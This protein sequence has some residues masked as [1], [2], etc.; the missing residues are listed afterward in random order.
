MAKNE[1]DLCIISVNSVHSSK[2]HQDSTSSGT[3]SKSS[4]M[5]ET[6]G[7]SAVANRYVIEDQVYKKG[8]S[9]NKHPNP[10]LD[11]R[12]MEVDEGRANKVFF[13]NPNER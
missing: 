5:R 9:R 12:G 13:D 8:S 1:R 10:E 6:K 3:K 11:V 2:L 4:T 7:H